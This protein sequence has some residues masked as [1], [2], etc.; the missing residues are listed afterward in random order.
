MN[1][2]QYYIDFCSYGAVGSG[3]EMTEGWKKNL[4]SNRLVVLDE[5]KKS[6]ETDYDFFNRNAPK[7]VWN[8]EK[9]YFNLNEGRHR[10]ALFVYEKRYTMPVAIKA[11]EYEEF[12]NSAGVL[13]A[14]QYFNSLEA[15][16]SLPVPI[17][18]PAFADLKCNRLQY[19]P[20]VMKTIMEFLS[21][22]LLCKNGVVNFGDLSAGLLVNDC[23][24][25]KRLL[26]KV[27][28]KV[29]N[30]GEVTTNE[31]VI[32]QVF[33]FRSDEIFTKDADILIFDTVSLENEVV[34][35]DIYEKNKKAQF[36]FYIMEVEKIEKSQE[37]YEKQGYRHKRLKSCFYGGKHAI[38]EVFYRE[39]NEKYITTII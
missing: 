11:E 1:K 10:A 12:Y 30:L 19:Y 26:S 23:G 22:F 3:V 33:K 32:D 31:K 16:V 4:I 27:G 13:R 8:Q 38:F 39:Q 35:E 17:S 29:W 9:R 36:I 15:G 7:A 14:Q 25:L 24:E 6:L 28:C 20:F 2:T 34:L 5:M 21:E 18:H 37:I